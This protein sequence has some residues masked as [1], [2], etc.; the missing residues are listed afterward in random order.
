MVQ[1]QVECIGTA[2][3]ST[4]S[5]P[6]PLSSDDACMHGIALVS[7]S[8]PGFQAVPSACASTPVFSSCSCKWYTHLSEQPAPA[9]DL[10]PAAQRRQQAQQCIIIYLYEAEA[11]PEK[12]HV[13]RQQ[14]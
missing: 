10:I 7:V 9:L 8:M 12:D 4:P 11:S 2:D 13:T 1:S 5:H 14:F 6:P 3:G